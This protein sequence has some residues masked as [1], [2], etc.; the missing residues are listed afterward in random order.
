MPTD[1][2][3]E[4]QSSGVMDLR[5]ATRVKNASSSAVAAFLALLAMS[6]WMGGTKEF[7]NILLS[8][9]PFF[10]CITSIALVFGAFISARHLRW[11]VATGALTG[12]AGGATLVLWAMSRI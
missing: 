6:L 3:G 8:A 5:V 11:S 9:V 1:R 7:F 4:S 10:L 12:F 2:T